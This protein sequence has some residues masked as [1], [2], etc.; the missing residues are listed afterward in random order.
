MSMSPAAL[1]ALLS[2][3]NKNFLAASTPGGI[4]AQ[5]RE[6]QIEQ[7]FKDTL[8]KEMRGCTRADFEAMGIEFLGPDEDEL[9]L[10]V[11]FPPGWRKRATEHSMHTELLDN[12]GRVRANIFYKAAFY[13]RRA[14]ITTL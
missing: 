11:K 1:K 3:D 2:G 12:E 9:F 8:P 13:D 6:G 14:N 4:E 5:E 10:K 7:S